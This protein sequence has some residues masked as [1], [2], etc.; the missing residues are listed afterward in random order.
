[1]DTARL[2]SPDELIEQIALIDLRLDA[3][4]R[5]GLADEA[6][7][8]APGCEGAQ[9]KALTMLVALR[10]ELVEELLERRQILGALLAKG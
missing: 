2:P 1:M 7:L 3:Q 6:A 4:R 9:R 10:D 5:M 8:L